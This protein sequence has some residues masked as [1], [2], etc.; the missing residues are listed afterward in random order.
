M[1]QSCHIAVQMKR[2]SVIGSPTLPRSDSRTSLQGGKK[3]LIHILAEA[4]RPNC[5]YDSVLVYLWHEGNTTTWMIPAT[6]HRSWY[7]HGQDQTL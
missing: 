7:M 1:L 3:K 6:G 2:A 5:H 4:G